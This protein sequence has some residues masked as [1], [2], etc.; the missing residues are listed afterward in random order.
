MTGPLPRGFGENESEKDHEITV[1]HFSPIRNERFIPRPA[2]LLA[3]VVECGMIHAA[4]AQHRFSRRKVEST[5]HVGAAIGE[6][7]IVAL[8]GPNDQKR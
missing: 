2:E 6:T 8:F 5:T 3:R 1:S 7:S 4:A